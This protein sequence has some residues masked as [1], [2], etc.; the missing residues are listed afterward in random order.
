MHCS[1]KQLPQGASICLLCALPRS[2]RL[3]LRRPSAIAQLTTSWD[4]LL[5]SGC[6]LSLMHQL[7]RVPHSRALSSQPPR[8]FPSATLRSVSWID[9]T[10]GLGYRALQT[11]TTPCLPAARG[12]VGSQLALPSPYHPRKWLIRSSSWFYPRDDI[13]EGASF[14]SCR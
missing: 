8:P 12:R 9:E 10:R 6:S 11:L 2:F 13:C 3:I 1:R 4:T 5:V 14:H 7:A